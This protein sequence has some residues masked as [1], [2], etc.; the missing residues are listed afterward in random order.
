MIRAWRVD[1]AVPGG[2]RSAPRD[3]VAPYV[4]RS[5]RVVL[6]GID[7]LVG[8]VAFVVLE[9]SDCNSGYRRGVTL[10]RVAGQ[11]GVSEATGGSSWDA[12]L[13][14]AELKAIGCTK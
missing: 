8:N 9:E 6:F 14:E 4:W 5:S 2:L 10:Q 12:F 1:L 7:S 3:S 11:W 13:S